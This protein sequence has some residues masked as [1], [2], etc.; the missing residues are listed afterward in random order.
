MEHTHFFK[1]AK[2]SRIKHALQQGRIVP[3]TPHYACFCGAAL[4]APDGMQEVAMI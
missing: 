4:V 2:K 1:Y 3:E